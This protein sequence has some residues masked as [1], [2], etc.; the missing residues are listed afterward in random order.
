MTAYVSIRQHMSA[1][2]SIRRMRQHTSAYVSILARLAPI[3]RGP[4]RVIRQHT[5]AY[6]SI[7]QHTSAFATCWLALRRFLEAL[8]GSKKDVS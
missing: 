2:V 3:S 6:A 8:L 4:T 7:R 1:Y 5:S